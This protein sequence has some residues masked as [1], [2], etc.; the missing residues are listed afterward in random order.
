MEN[1]KQTR[2]LILSNSQ[3]FCQTVRE[4]IQQYGVIFH[5]KS[6][7]SAIESL[8]NG[9]YS[10]IIIDKNIEKTDSLQYNTLLLTTFRKN[11]SDLTIIFF[12]DIT[13]SDI[14]KYCRYCIPNLFFLSSISIF[15]VPIIKRILHLIPDPDRVV[16]KD[17]GI[18][19]YLNCNYVI[20][21]GCKIFLTKTEMLILQYLLKK[22]SVCSKEELISHLSKTIGKEISLAY[23][24]VNISRLRKKIFKHTG[25]K[26]VKNRNG[27]GYYI[28]V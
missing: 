25:V 16:L 5:C 3:S 27:F 20:Y 26:L 14:L 24:T 11:L 8:S 19:L 18:S 17:R 4:N 7:A 23:L 2:F 28:S 1:L 15:L 9:C 21:K 12:E 10:A 6:I 13:Q 22:N